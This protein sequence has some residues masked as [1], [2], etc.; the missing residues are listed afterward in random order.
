M[1]QLAEVVLIREK[2]IEKNGVVDMKPLTIMDIVPAK[3][4]SKSYIN[5]VDYDSDVTQ[6]SLTI[7]LRTH[8]LKEDLKYVKVN[9]KKF[10][11]V[12]DTVEYETDSMLDLLEVIDE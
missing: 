12:N 3:I 10:K 2:F 5:A 4:I 9:E 7:R 6:M 1:N 8:S 11:I